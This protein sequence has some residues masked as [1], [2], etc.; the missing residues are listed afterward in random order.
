[1]P[2]EA[3][4]TVYI[5][6]LYIQALV[7]TNQNRGATFGLENNLEAEI[8]GAKKNYLYVYA[9]LVLPLLIR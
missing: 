9:L 4:T 3:N 7:A 2:C 8:V 6:F 5:R 1:M